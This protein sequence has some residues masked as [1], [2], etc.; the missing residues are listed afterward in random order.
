M[1]MLSLVFILN[2]V[3]IS[4]LKLVAERCYPEP[5][6][7][8]FKVQ[9]E[10]QSYPD[11]IIKAFYKI[12]PAP[13]SNDDTTG[14]LSGS[15]DIIYVPQGR[16]GQRI[17]VWLMDNKGNIDYRGSATTELETRLTNIHLFNIIAKENF[18]FKINLG[19]GFLSRTGFTTLDSSFTSSVVEKFGVETAIEKGLTEL[20]FRFNALGSSPDIP[21]GNLNFDLLKGDISISRKQELISNFFGA[22][23]FIGWGWLQKNGNLWAKNNSTGKEEEILHEIQRDKGLSVGVNLVKYIIPNIVMHDKTRLIGIKMKYSYLFYMEGI[24][25]FGIEFIF[26]SRFSKKGFY[27]F[28]LGLN[29]YVGKDPNT[30]YTLWL[31]LLNGTVYF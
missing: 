5:D 22:E 10:N 30:L 2:N 24:N 29:G 9:W 6:S 4:P 26:F 21:S 11:S 8:M 25:E 13:I 1:L 19:V 23:P 7:F 15:P 31:D 28:T 12:G 16:D 18:Y 14:S 3:S 17:F 27:L 20:S